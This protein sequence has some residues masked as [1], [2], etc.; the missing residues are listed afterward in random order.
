MG[1]Q[2][3]R[4]RIKSVRRTTATAAAVIG[5]VLVT[6]SACGASPS[7]G[8]KNGLPGPHARAQRDPTAPK[9]AAGQE[10][11]RP[12][13]A[14]PVGDPGRLPGVGELLQAE[15]PADSRQAVAVYG[16]GADSA[17]STVVLYTRDG[18]GWRPV[19]SWP[20]HNGRSGWTTD[21][22][23]GDGRSPVGVFTVTDAGGVLP[24]PGTRLSYAQGQDLYTPPRSWSPAYRHDFD[25]VIAIDYNRLRGTP[26]HDTTHPWGAG[27][28]GGI[29]LH[30]DHGS[31][32]SACIG[33][34][35]EAMEYL[36]R[37]LDP[38]RDPVVVM[39]DRPSLLS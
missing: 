12:D 33:L 29:W 16:E 20:A 13:R 24:D 15:I 6:L 11:Q 14:V 10:W 26:P 5:S 39:G 9:A 2:D 35:G 8:A 1:C 18:S 34:P 4:V 36:L 3:G 23:A 27:R 31:G 22:Y 37:T 28:G 38:A 25:Y 32:T 19:G 30:L 17:D 21:H 7:G